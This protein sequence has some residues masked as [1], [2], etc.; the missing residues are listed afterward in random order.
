[1]EDAYAKH[2]WMTT[3]RASRRTDAEER[4]ASGGLLHESSPGKPI[5]QYVLKRLTAIMQSACATSM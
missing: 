4:R 1:M 3:E 2:N 5:E